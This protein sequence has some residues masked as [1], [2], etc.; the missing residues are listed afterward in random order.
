M[1]GDAADRCL[2]DR[3][4]FGIDG[5]LSRVRRRPGLDGVFDF[6]RIDEDWLSVVGDQYCG[7][8]SHGFIDQG[9]DCLI[10]ARCVQLREPRAK[11]FDL[12]GMDV[13]NRELQHP[14]I[15]AW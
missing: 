4:V 6:H 11:T 7:L 2:G 5:M 14:E 12:T 15:M 10:A 9:R 1:V 13:A 3:S 8:M